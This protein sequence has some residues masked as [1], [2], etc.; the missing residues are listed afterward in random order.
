MWMQARFSLD[1]GSKSSSLTLHG[2]YRGAARCQKFSFW[3]KAIFAQGDGASM[4]GA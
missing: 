4:H 2:L 3:F 1:L